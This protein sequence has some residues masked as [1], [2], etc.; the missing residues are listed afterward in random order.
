M[1]LVDIEGSFASCLMK[2]AKTGVWT[3]ATLAEGS[4]TPGSTPR[5]A[6]PR[7]RGTDRA[8]RG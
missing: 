1:I 6:A 2:S 8:A 3:A 4:R 5:G 7:H